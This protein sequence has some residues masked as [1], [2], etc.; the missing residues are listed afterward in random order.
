ML[1]DMLYLP[2]ITVIVFR[3]RRTRKVLRADTFP[4]STNSVT[5][6]K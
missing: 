3:A 6:L 1:N 2:G 4:K 5:Y